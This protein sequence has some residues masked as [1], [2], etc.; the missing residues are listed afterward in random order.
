MVLSHKNAAYA[1]FLCESL[2][3]QICHLRVALNE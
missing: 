2:Y 3:I 1:A